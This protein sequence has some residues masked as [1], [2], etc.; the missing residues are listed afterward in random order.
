M[1]RRIN[2]NGM[3]CLS[4]EILLEKE[5]KNLKWVKLLMVSHKKWVME[6]DYSKKQDYE[7]VL[8]IIKNNWFSL[9]ELWD[10]NKKEN[11]LSNIIAILIILI[12]S[13]FSYLFNLSAYIPDTSS[14]SYFSAFLVWIIASVSTCLA[15]TWWIIIGF[16]KYIDSSHSKIWHFKVQIWF[17]FWRL[18]GFFLFWWVLWLTWQLINFNFSLSWFLTFFIWILL[19]YMG[20]HIMWIIPSI[21]RFWVHMPKS[22]ASKIEKLWKPH[23]SPLVWALTFFLPCWFTQSIQLLAVS[24]WNFWLWW[25][26]MLFFALGTFPILFSVWLWASY[27][28]EKPLVLLNKIIASLLI[29]FWLVTIFNSYKLINFDSIFNS[30]KKSSS[31]SSIID[32]N[33][34]IIEVWHD[35]WNT[36]PREII[37]EKW[38][39]YRVVVTPKQNGRWCMSTQFVPKLNSKVSYVKAWEKIV[40]EFIEAKPWEYEM[41]CASMWMLQWKIIVK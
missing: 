20:L 27:F 16:S 39:N 31:I 23:L 29:F 40:Y 26:V 22:F 32:W 15:I 19:F 12:L 10:V 11:F 6:I 25:F 3:H 8:K 7:K 5:L 24:S 38:K 13:I 41:L 30:W 18:L 17:Q 14:L 34:E 2:I 35:G 28:K 37:L 1:K 9:K 33:F 36:V 4:C 21:T